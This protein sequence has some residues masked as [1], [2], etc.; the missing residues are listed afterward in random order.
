MNSCGNTMNNRLGPPSDSIPKDDIAGKI[1][2]PA[3][4][5]TAMFISTTEIPD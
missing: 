2:S 4:I 5:D 1:A 3:I